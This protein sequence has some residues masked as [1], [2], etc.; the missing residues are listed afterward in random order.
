MIIIHWDYSTGNE[1]SYIEG[2]ELK[3]NFTTC[4]LDFFSFDTN[5]DE[6]IV[7]RK[8]GMYISRNNIQQHTVKEIR[9]EH[10]LHKMLLAGSFEWL[11]LN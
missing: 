6:V 2:I 3:D 7:L 4:C 10:N 11:F 9:K 8:D 1:V 5:V